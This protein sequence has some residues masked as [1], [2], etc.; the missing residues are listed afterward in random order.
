MST[1]NTPNPGLS[2]SQAVDMLL[3]PQEEATEAPKGQAETPPPEAPTDGADSPKEQ[4]EA[5]AAPNVDPEEQALEA[6]L[7]EAEES[8]DDEEQEAPDS[9]DPEVAT[10][11]V[12]EEHSEESAEVTEARAIQPDDVIFHDPEGNPVTAEEAH[13]GYLRQADYTRKTQ[14]IAAEREQLTEQLQARQ[15]EREVVGQYINIALSAIEPILAEGQK[16]DWDALLDQNPALYKQK[17]EQ[18][19]RAEQRFNQ[20]AEAGRK[21]IEA[22]EAERQEQREKH[23]AAHREVAKRLIPELADPKQAPIVAQRIGAYLQKGA[24]FSPEEAAKL[25]DARLLMLAHKALKYDLLQA[26]G[27]KVKDKKVR[28]AP[29]AG[30]KP[31]SPK[32]QAQRQKQDRADKEARLR[33]TGDLRD[34]VDLLLTGPT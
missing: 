24:G 26:Q 30:I 18:Y 12:D 16:T 21:Q 13:R 4:P 23:I 22:A 11:E 7:G 2:D 17:R 9:E 32:T 8:S 3:T 19:V 15:Q 28:A 27:R 6:L 31:G 1:E 10:G 20:L 14:E 29:K 34:A 5:E 25:G 33:R